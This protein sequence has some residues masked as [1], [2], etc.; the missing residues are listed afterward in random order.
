MRLR[1]ALIF[2]ADAATEIRRLFIGPLLP[3]QL[4][5]RDRLGVLPYP[6]GLR[7]QV[8]HSHDVGEAY[9]LAVTQL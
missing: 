8:V 7:T 4:M 6:R 9:R 5:R 3:N 1:P 2:K